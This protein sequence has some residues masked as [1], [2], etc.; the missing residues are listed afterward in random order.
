MADKGLRDNPHSARPPPQQESQRATDLLPIRQSSTHMVK[1]VNPVRTLGGLPIMHDVG[2]EVI[3]SVLVHSLHFLRE[4]FPQVHISE[5]KN[6]I[7]KG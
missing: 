6:S 4:I 7:N 5:A 2:D 3:G 1:H